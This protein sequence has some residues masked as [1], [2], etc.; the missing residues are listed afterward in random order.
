LPG[1]ACNSF[2][3]PS[4]I[5]GTPAVK[6]TPSSSSKRQIEGPSIELPGKTCLTPSIQA[7]YGRPHALAWN[8]GT[9]AMTVSIRVNPRKSGNAP[10]TV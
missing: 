10:V 8:I 9:A 4:Q 5:V 3:T 7:V 6:V 1:F 2:I